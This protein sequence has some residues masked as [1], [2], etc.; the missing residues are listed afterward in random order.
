MIVRR[1]TA[2]A[3][4]FALAATAF[5]AAPAMAKTNTTVLKLDSAT[6]EAVGLVGIKPEA[7]KPAKLK[8]TT[9]TI[10]AKLKGKSITHKGGLKLTNGTAFLTV[11]DIKINYKTGKASATVDNSVTGPLPIKNVLTF[12]G[13][14][15]TIKKNGKWKNANVALA[16]SVNVPNLGKMNVAAVLGLV[17]GLPEETIDQVLPAPIAIG[18]ANITVKKKK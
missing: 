3:A 10:P 9:L 14:K 11:E 8:K 12:K 13:G 2:G 4:G 1:I 7:V 18:K 17:F 6:L 15:N 5:A 16:K